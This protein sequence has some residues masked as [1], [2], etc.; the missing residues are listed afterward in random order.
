MPRLKALRDVLAV[1]TNE[2]RLLRRS[3]SAILISLVVIPLF[4]TSSL[5][6]GRGRAGEDYSTTAKLP[7]AFIDQDM[8]AASGNLYEVL[9][10]SKDFNMLIQGHTEEEVIATLG[11]GG[12]FAAIIVPKGFQENL[13][14][15]NTAYITVYYD[16]GS[17]GM[18]DVVTSNI[19]KNIV[20]FSPT[21]KVIQT[22]QPSGFAQIQI[23]QK[24][25]KFSGFSVGLT[26]TMVMVVVFATFYEIAGSMSRE[27]ES[28]T[29]ARLLVTPISLGAVM[30]GKTLYDTGL[31]IVRSFIVLGLAI[32]VYGARL[33]TDLATVLIS[34]LLIAILTM[35]FGF[36]VASLGVGVRAVV[37]IEFFLVL[38][39]FAFS[40]FI[41]DKE[42]MRGI[43]QT[44]ST[45]LP[46]AYGI[47]V[48]KRTILIGQPL[49][50]LTY[51]LQIIGLSITVF[52]V[53]AYL[54]LRSS[55]E[56]L[57]R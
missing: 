29:Y 27:R 43:T 42:L 52:Y 45:V 38:F 48:F 1:I 32:Y 8:T 50:S 24:G 49:T 35:G 22:F 11:K 40:G 53:V 26:I 12:I 23:L 31:N 57:I 10:M 41:I 37:I 13:L 15:G 51:Q 20:N 16:D 44:I 14:A 21:S 34:T 3:R 18:L 30:V 28:G 56:R 36:L 25:T 54:M 2:S 9:A 17:L 33:N 4:F 6:A 55:R 47:D 19:Q 5:G 39:L 46:W 7:I